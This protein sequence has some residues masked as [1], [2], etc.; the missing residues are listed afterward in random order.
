MK[1]EVVREDGGKEERGGKCI[2]KESVGE[3]EE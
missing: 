1:S 3:W 2:S